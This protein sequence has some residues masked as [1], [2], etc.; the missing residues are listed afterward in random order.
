[1]HSTACYVFLIILITCYMLVGVLILILV[2]SSLL[3]PHNPSSLQLE[4]T[5]VSLSSAHSM[6]NL[7]LPPPDTAV[8]GVVAMSSH[9]LPPPSLASGASQEAASGSFLGLPHLC[10]QLSD[11]GL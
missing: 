1:M 5:A 8:R 11:P 3:T 9:L 7:P 2:A 4:I 10:P 6:H